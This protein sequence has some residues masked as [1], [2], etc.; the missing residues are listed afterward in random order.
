MRFPDGY[1]LPLRDAL[2]EMPYVRQ[3]VF[4][5]GGVRRKGEK[6]LD[7]LSFRFDGTE[8]RGREIVHAVRLVLGTFGSQLAY[9]ASN[10]GSVSDRTAEIVYERP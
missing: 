9:S 3:A 1:R 8:P 7:L 5:P 6:N 4:V 10:G 2:T